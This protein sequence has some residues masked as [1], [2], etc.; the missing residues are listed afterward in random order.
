[1]SEEGKDILGVLGGLMVVFVLCLG[2]LAGM[3]V[4]LRPSD[5][6]ICITAGYEWRGGDCVMGVDYE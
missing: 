2:V 6:Q 1:M 4:M 3:K 5:M